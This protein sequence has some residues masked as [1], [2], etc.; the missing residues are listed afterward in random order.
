MAA[1]LFGSLSLIAGDGITFLGNAIKIA[2]RPTDSGLE[3]TG[4][5]LGIDIAS[6][7]P[8]T[9]SGGLAL[10]QSALSITES[11]VSDLPV[12]YKQGDI[13]LAAEGSLGGAGFGFE[14]SP[15]TGM[16]HFGT[17]V[18]GFIVA[19]VSVLELSKP[20]GAL[21]ATVEYDTDS[22]I[23]NAASVYSMITPKLTVV[24]TSVT[25]GGQIELFE[26]S[27][28]GT[29]RLRLRCPN[30]LPGTQTWHLPPTAVL[31]GVWKSDASGVL[32]CE[33]VD[34]AELVSVPTTFTPTS[35]T[36]A[37]S[38]IISGTFADARISQSS[39]TQHQAS[40]SITESQVS[41]LQA[42]YKQGDTI[43]ADD[44]T[45]LLP[46]ISFANDTDSGMF[47]GVVAGVLGT[48]DST[49]IVHNGKPLIFCQNFFG[50]FTAVL[51]DADIVISKGALEWRVIA[52]TTNFI[53]VSTSSGA[54]ISI[55]EGSANG[56]SSI[57][58]KVPDS[59]SVS[60]TWVLPPTAVSSGVWKSNASGT[61]VCEKIV[62]VN[63]VAVDNPT[64]AVDKTIFF[65][66][67]AITIGQM[68]AVV[69]GT[70]PS[71][72]FRVMH[73]SNRSAAGNAVVTAGNVAANQTTGSVVTI[74]DDATILA[75]SWV[76]LEVTAVSGTV[77]EF[78][79]SINHT[80]D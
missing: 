34:Y 20:M 69:R 68:T 41:G 39:V 1:D 35:H 14:D 71:V 55:F 16:Y 40:L 9:T 59:L 48:L 15:D 21:F 32:I 61:L 73:S 49:A 79:L 25:T 63:A 10:D 46:G 6:G 78:A 23:V 51:M 74:F 33:A 22:Y 53:N 36:H 30:S 58:L 54:S 52:A 62:L 28:N 3:L 13:I 26:G 44:G 37:A 80:E 43:L 66:T 5:V 50:S 72:T 12:Y 29:S 42:Y 57:S 17:N 38:D 56:I 24:N 11:Q 65:T 45:A 4:G 76:W 27:A 19:G 8:F 18:L 7:E 67:K 70:S 31:N 64:T 60:V 75:G 2:L 77:E 47:S